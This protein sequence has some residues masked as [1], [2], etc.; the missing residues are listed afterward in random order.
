MVRRMA[1][2][3][4]RVERSSRRSSVSVFTARAN[5]SGS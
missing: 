4:R 2:S 3:L 1:V 5:I